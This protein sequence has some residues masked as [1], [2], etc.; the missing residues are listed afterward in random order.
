MIRQQARQFIR[1]ASTG[2]ASK[3]GSF[4]SSADATLDSRFK[5]SERQTFSVLFYAAQILA[6]VSVVLLAVGYLKAEPAAA[7]ARIFAALALFVVCYLLMGMSGP[8][9]AE[10]FRLYFG[11]WMPLLVIASNGISGLFMLYCFLIFQEARRLP[12]LLV[13]LFLAQLAASTVMV[14]TG[15]ARSGGES[16]II[17]SVLTL[18]DLVQLGFV[19]L[20]IYWTFSG[21]R[22][23]LVEDRRVFR[24]FVIGVQGVLIFFVL[25]LENFLLTG[26]VQ[27]YSSARELTVYAIALLA[28]GMLVVSM[29]F[30]Y[31]SLTQAIRKVTEREEEEEQTRSPFDVNSFNALF[32]GGAMYREAGL[33]IAVLAQ[34]LGMPEYRLRSFIH[35]ELGYRNFN[36]MLHVYRV[37]EACAILADSQ[38]SHLPVLTVALSVGYQSIT[39]F[40]NAFRELKGVTPS[41]FRKRASATSV[42]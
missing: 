9:V 2:F 8:S 31:V 17:V 37:D 28:F 6:I 36:A 42:E 4:A 32:R 41:E 13:G 39:P 33:T 25:F 20:A 38:Q 5:I 29:K 7:S 3:E 30:D 14:L 35:K 34:K 21:W 10:P 18:I 22:A 24:W 12:P 40:N 1:A 27:A 26:G 23:D 15:N 16:E 19:C 11:T